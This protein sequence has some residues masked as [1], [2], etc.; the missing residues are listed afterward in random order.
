M[1]L[2][3]NFVRGLVFQSLMNSFRV[4]KRF[5][6]FEDA[7]SCIIE[8]LKLFKLGPLMFQR[9]EESFDN[10]VVV[11]ASGAAHGKTD[12][13]GQTNE[14]SQTGAA[15]QGQVQ[16]TR[17]QVVI[18]SRNNFDIRRREYGQGNAGASVYRNTG[19][20]RRYSTQRFD[21]EHYQDGSSAFDSTCI[22]QS[23]IAPSID[24]V[25]FCC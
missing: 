11:T 6:V 2:S 5:D 14:Q 15:I 9:P 19:P 16:Q 25:W 21:A 13:R 22:M 17:R 4:V 1:V 24:T 12:K 3:F 18:G 8:I 7:H 20:T 23:R 10:C